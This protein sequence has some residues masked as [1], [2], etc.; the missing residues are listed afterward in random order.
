MTIC[1][2]TRSAV[3]R[4]GYDCG[5]MQEFWWGREDDAFVWAPCG[6]GAL[7]LARDGVWRCEACA[8]PWF[9]LEVLDRRQIHEQLEV[10]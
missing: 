10:V 3:I 8:P 1:L 5:V 6:H 9:E 2:A 7:W 4:P